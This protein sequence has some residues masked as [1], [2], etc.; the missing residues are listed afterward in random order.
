MV[1]LCDLAQEKRTAPNS[2]EP[3]KTSTFQRLQDVD[4]GEQK[5]F[6]YALWDSQIMD[7]KTDRSK[8]GSK[9]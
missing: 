1:L 8:L 9:V 3:Q 7:F 4:S 6:L 5:K 2:A